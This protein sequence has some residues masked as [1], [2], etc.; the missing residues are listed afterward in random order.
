M[1]NK[2]FIQADLDG[3]QVLSKKE[4]RN[5]LR[6]MHINMSD[7]FFNQY[8]NQYDHDQNGMID[9]EEFQIMTLNLMCK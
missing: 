6:I 9:Q 2:L 5:L 7:K 8:F 1:A 3:N 4:I